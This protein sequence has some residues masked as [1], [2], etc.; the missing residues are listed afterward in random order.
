VE[1]DQ[2]DVSAA[3]VIGDL[4]QVDDAEKARFARQLRRDVGK[5]DGLDGIDFDLSFLHRIPAAHLHVRARPDTDA[6]RDLAVANP[7]AQPFGEHHRPFIILPKG[8]KL[9]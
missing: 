1:A 2:V 5:A 9:R 7:F 4:E 8:P 6:A 3:A